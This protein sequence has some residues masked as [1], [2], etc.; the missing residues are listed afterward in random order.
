MLVMLQDGRVA[1]ITKVGVG[2]AGFAVLKIPAVDTNLIASVTKRNNIAG[3]RGVFVG[4][5]Y[6]ASVNGESPVV[7]VFRKGPEGAFVLHHLL[8]VL[9]LLMSLDAEASVMAYVPARGKDSG[10]GLWLVGPDGT[11]IE[12]AGVLTA[13]QMGGLLL[14]VSALNTETYFVSLNQAGIQSL[15]ELAT[16]V[17]PPEGLE[18]GRWTWRK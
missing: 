3:E 12:L 7:P 13:A 4:W 18:E 2:N 8:G 9:G 5:N 1:P 11:P 14:G 17:E 15:I 6:L 10:G 16:P